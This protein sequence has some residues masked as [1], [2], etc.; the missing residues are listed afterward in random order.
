MKINV[1]A[2]PYKGYIFLP[3]VIMLLFK[4]GNKSLD[5][6]ALGSLIAVASEC[7][8]DKKHPT[9]GCLNK[10][11]EQLAVRWSC[12][13]ST[14]WRKKMRLKQLGLLQESENGLFRLNYI[15]WFEAPT[16]KELARLEIAD[17]QELIA[18]TQELIASSQRN[19]ADMQEPQ[20]HNYPQSFN[21]SSK[22]DL[23][24]G[25]NGKGY[26]S[27]EIKKLEEA[28]KIGE[29]LFEND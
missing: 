6:G 4:N 10:T 8:W 27:D 18:K 21:V 20:F 3:R 14:V 15:E 22:E 29:E 28:W 9:Y 17:S 24:V 1:K 13:L 16:A 2:K 12:D 19:I 26:S 23:S 5:F 25:F 11:D 7:D